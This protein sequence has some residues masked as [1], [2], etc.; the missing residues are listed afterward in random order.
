MAVLGFELPSTAWEEWGVASAHFAAFYFPQ[1]ALHPGYQFAG[2]TAMM[3]LP[4][5]LAWPAYTA[6]RAAAR[7]AAAD[8][9]APKDA[10]PQAPPDPNSNSTAAAPATTPA[11]RT[12]IGGG[13]QGL[14]KT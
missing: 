11:P 7:K 2:S 9:K 4:L 12:S 8:A 14:P 10:D 5:V 1:A 6:K 13:W 3:A